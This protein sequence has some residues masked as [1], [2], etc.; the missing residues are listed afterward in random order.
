MTD[1]TESFKLQSEG[2][3]LGSR[4]ALLNVVPC[5]GWWA[6]GTGSPLEVYDHAGQCG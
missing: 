1:Y 2:L 6:V 5:E 4:N 3:R